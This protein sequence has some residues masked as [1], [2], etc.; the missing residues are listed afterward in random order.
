MG[1]YDKSKAKGRK[2]PP[3]YWIN[4][5]VNGVQY[6]EPAR[7]SDRRT[8][9]DFYRQRLREI[10]DGCWV[11]PGDRPKQRRPTVAEYFEEWKPLRQAAG[12]SSAADEFTRIRKYVLPQLGEKRLDTV[13]R[14]DL[15]THRVGADAGLRAHRRPPS[16]KNRASRV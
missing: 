15:V 10:E 4:Y 11:P 13:E 16:A 1:V 7:T 2:S 8:A 5:S 14:A 6:R 3:N 12:V 9:E